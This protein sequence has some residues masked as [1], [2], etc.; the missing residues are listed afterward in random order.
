M[1]RTARLLLLCILTSCGGPPALQV[2]ELS[3]TDGIL[4]HVFNQKF[5]V[6]FTP[7]EGSNIARI[8]LNSDDWIELT[9]DRINK[10]LKTNT[11]Y[12]NRQEVKIALKPNSGA[13]GFFLPDGERQDYLILDTD[14]QMVSLTWR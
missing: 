12:T 5:D 10:T 1:A 7:F 6:T 2:A 14:G 8:A 4:K 11:H 9:I 13:H 3:A